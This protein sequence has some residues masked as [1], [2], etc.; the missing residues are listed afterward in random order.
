MLG[1]NLW[2]QWLKKSSVPDGPYSFVRQ[3]VA[4]RHVLE[5]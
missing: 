4:E 3:L 1:A 5:I 2:S